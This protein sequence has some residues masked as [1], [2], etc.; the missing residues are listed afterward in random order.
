[1]TT[2][3]E[4]D[5]CGDL[6]AEREAVASVD[7][8]INTRNEQLHLCAACAPDFLKPQFP[9]EYY[10][11]DNDIATDGGRALDTAPSIGER[12]TYIDSDGGRHPALVTWVFGDDPGPAPMINCAQGEDFT[13]GATDATGGDYGSRVTHRTSVSH[14][15]DMDTHAYTRGWPAGVGDVVYCG[16]CGTKHRRNALVDTNTPLEGKDG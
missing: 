2:H 13:L 16:E 10:P 15:T 12:V 11:P 1:M 5:W 3:F 4:C 6:F 14:R 9:D 7:I 8:T